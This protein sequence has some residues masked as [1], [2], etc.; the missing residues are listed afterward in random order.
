MVLFWTKCQPM[1]YEKLHRFEQI[2][3]DVLAMSLVLFY[4]YSAIVEP[5]ATQYHRG[6]YIII[7]YVLVFMLYRTPT[8]WGRILDYGLIAVSIVT[9]GYWI[10]NFEVIDGLREGDRLLLSDMSRWASADRI[11]V[12]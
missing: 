2:L 12:Q 1:L 6:I 7:T 9:I 5:A 3:F 10:L 4:S 11:R 8:V